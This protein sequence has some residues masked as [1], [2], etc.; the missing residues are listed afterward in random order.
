MITTILFDLDDTLLDFKGAEAKAL[1]ETLIQLDLVP[2]EKTISRY[3]AINQSQ[4]EL[5]EEGRITRDQVLHRRFDI[6]FQEL[7]IHRSSH[8]AQDI[9][10]HLLGQQHDL[11]LGAQEL[12]EELY[13]TYKLYLVSNGTAT[14]QDSRLRD[15][16]IDRY[17][18]KIF[19]SER[20]GANKPS[21]VF[22]DRCFAAMPGQERSHCLI[23]G[24]SL[25]SDILGGI[26]AGIQTCWFNP[27]KK[28]PRDGIHPDHEISALSQLPALLLQLR[29]ETA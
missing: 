20:I 28:Q 10:E 2:T 3:S 15:S 18:E 27:N 21:P 9:Y 29:Q 4:W 8:Q 24:D 1:R 25:S 12:L 22:F 11:I 13:G 7:G 23:V 14:V 17:F 19:I 5:L 6:L 16:G 26:N